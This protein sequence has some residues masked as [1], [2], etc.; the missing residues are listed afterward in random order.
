MQ[1]S[2]KVF[3]RKDKGG[4]GNLPELIMSEAISAECVRKLTA[5][6]SEIGFQPIHDPEHW[7]T[8]QSETIFNRGSR[9]KSNFFVF[10][11]TNGKRPVAYFT[12]PGR[13]YAEVVREPRMRLECAPDESPDEWS[14]RVRSSGCGWDRTFSRH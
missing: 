7:I 11:D 2:S 1:R 6:L 9:E 12:N 13:D 10:V 8:D 3:V 5:A 14:R 4:F